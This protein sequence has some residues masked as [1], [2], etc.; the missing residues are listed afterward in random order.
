M[1]SVKLAYLPNLGAYV[2]WKNG[3][4]IGCVRCRFPLPFCCPVE[5][6]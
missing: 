1:G 4:I 3:K 5:F 2:V 6:Q